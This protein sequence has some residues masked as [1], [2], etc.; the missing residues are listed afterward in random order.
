MKSRNGDFGWL[1]VNGNI[2]RRGKKFWRLIVN[3]GGEGMEG[4]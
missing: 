2:Q 4:Q 3:W 1:V